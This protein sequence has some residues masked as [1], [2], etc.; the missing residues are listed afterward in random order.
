MA[1]QVTVGFLPWPATPQ[2]DAAVRGR[3]THASFLT[4]HKAQAILTGIRL[5]QMQRPQ[6]P[7]RA[8]GDLSGSPSP[9]SRH[10]E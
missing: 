1:D 3:E 5:P 10:S 8:C 9:K 7:K 6:G 4:S 2:R